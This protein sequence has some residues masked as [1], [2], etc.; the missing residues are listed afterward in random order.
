MIEQVKDI[1]LSTFIQVTQGIGISMEELLDE[2]I[3]AKS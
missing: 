3:W 2:S 1:W